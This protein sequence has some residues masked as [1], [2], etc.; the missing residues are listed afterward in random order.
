MIQYNWII[1]AME[2]YPKADGLDNVVFQVHYRRQATEVDGEKTWFAETYSVVNVPA[3]SPDDYTPYEDL[4]FEQVCGWLEGILN[5]EAIDESLAN[6]IEDQKN[7][8]V[9]Q[10]PLPWSTPTEV[11]SEEKIEEP[12]SIDETK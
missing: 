10:L 12:L 5:V 1:S 11:V 6:Q 9:L 8:K 4:T 3:P 2:N 7:P